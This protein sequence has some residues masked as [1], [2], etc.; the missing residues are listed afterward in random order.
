MLPV[1]LASCSPTFHWTTLCPCSTPLNFRT[2]LTAPH[3][4]SLLPAGGKG[5]AWAAHT[6]PQQRSVISGEAAPLSEKDAF[7]QRDAAADRM[8]ISISS[9][10][11][12]VTRALP[13]SGKWGFPAE[14]PAFSYHKEPWLG[15]LLGEITACNFTDTRQ[16]HVLCSARG[17][18]NNCIYFRMT[19]AN[20]FRQAKLAWK[21]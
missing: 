10:K 11:L 2:V 9:D 20:D 13:S 4:A 1:C 16:A 19:P 12:T 8:H 5:W 3:G 17:R 6:K 7:S 21:G 18:D 15:A 14:N